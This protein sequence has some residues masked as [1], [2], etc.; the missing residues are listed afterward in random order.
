MPASTRFHS[1]FSGVAA[2]RVAGLAA[3]AVLF[4]AGSASAL[5]LRFGARVG[6]G[7]GSYDGDGSGDPDI[8][9]FAVGAAARLDLVLLAVEVDLLWRKNTWETAGV[10]TEIQRLAIPVIARL[11]FPLVPGLLTAEIGAGLEPRFLLSAEFG[12]VDVS[13]NLNDQVLYLPLVAGLDLDLKVI[14]AGIEVRYER[15]LT[16]EGDDPDF[17]IHQLMFFG[18]VFF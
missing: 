14:G 6:G 8:S 16:N 5:G 3:A 13:K 12:G 11:G 4:T 9:A 1:V 10:D 15:Q 7:T 2:R 17:K 18:G